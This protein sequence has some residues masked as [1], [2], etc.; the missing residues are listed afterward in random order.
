MFAGFIRENVYYVVENI[1]LGFLE[2]LVRSCIYLGF[3]RSLRG[4]RIKL[5]RNSGKEKMEEG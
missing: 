2:S 1:E 5:F 3:F 4:A